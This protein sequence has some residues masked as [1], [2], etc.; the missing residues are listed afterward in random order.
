MNCVLKKLKKDYRSIFRNPAILK[1]IAS[2]NYTKQFNSSSYT[3]AVGKV[4][5][6]QYN[7]SNSFSDL[8]LSA[9]AKADVN[10]SIRLLSAFPELCSA[11][12]DWYIAPDPK[13]FFKK[14]GFD[15]IE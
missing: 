6:W 10:N 12:A 11:Y 7:N 4:F 15:V 14:Y 13:K 5:Y 1:T 9:I 8:I 3:D 2:E